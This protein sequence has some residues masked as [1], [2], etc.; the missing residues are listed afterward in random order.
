MDWHRLP[1]VLVRQRNLQ[2]LSCIERV[3]NMKI[4]SPNFRQLPLGT[5]RTHSNLNSHTPNHSFNLFQSRTMPKPIFCA[6]ELTCGRWLHVDVMQVNQLK[7]GHTDKKFED[8][9]LL[10]R[11]CGGVI[12]VTWR[13]IFSG[14][15]SSLTHC[16]RVNHGTVYLQ[17]PFH[18]TK[19]KLSALKA[20]VRP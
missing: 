16:L 18:S 12:T 13:L 4:W 1:Q 17:V 5:W 9:S 14:L 11:G 8:M 2:F 3:C 19:S 6:K 10:L 15:L 7:L 20:W